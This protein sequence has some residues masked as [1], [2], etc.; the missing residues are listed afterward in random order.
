M[1]LS[2]GWDIAKTSIQVFKKVIHSYRSN[3]YPAN[4]NK[5]KTR[6]FN[7]LVLKDQAK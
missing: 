5:S 4:V 2:R 3:K 1:T 6:I 7:V